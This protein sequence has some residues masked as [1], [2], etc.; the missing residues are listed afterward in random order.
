M[1]AA[2]QFVTKRSSPAILPH[3]RVMDGFARATVPEHGC[4]TLIR[5]ANRGNIP[6]SQTRLPQGCARD[7][8]LA[9]PDLFGIV[10]D[11]TG[12]RKYLL[13]FLLGDCPD[14][15]CMIKHNRPGT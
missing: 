7:L 3:N 12:L 8:E 1:S 10:L 4:F 9:E 15:T 11:P 2:F 6:C 14:R 13:E 5:D